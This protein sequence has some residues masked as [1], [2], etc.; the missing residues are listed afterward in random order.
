MVSRNRARGFQIPQV[1]GNN[2]SVYL[3][4]EQAAA[5]GAALG[6]RK[7]TNTAADDRAWRQQQLEEK[8]RRAFERERMQYARE[9]A[10]LRQRTQQ[11][12]AAM[13]TQLSQA[14]T[15]AS[16]PY[17]PQIQPAPLIA[18]EIPR[19]ANIGPGAMGRRA[20]HDAIQ[21][22]QARISLA[23]PRMPR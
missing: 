3:K 10:E 14:I 16:N 17:A 1:P 2:E 18:P 4:P 11:E 21:Q 6:Q 8:E 12:V 13:E 22:A 23:A 15:L 5:E 19:G 20:P 9:L 7:P